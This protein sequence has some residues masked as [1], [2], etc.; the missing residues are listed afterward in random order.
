MQ[1]TAHPELSA[2]PEAVE[3]VPAGVEGW[4]DVCASPELAPARPHITRPLSECSSP[5]VSGHT[6]N[7][8]DPSCQESPKRRDH[9]LLSALAQ[10][11]FRRVCG[12]EL[13]VKRALVSFPA[14]WIQGCRGQQCRARRS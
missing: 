7:C 4:S 9:Q 5:G 12:R 1:W 10:I 2:S 6:M 3:L 14:S 11:C 8:G 13:A